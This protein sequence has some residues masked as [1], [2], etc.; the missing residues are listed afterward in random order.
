LARVYSHAW[1]VMGQ[2]FYRTITEE[3]LDYVV[4]EMTYVGAPAND[5]QMLPAQR[6]PSTAAG[7]AFY[8]TYGA[9]SKGEGGQVLH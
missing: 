3:T 9:D 8:S 7:I 2:P 4:R 1:Q 6:L 5:Q